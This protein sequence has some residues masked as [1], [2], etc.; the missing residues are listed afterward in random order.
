MKPAHRQAI[1]HLVE[2]LVLDVHRILVE[3][4][5]FVN[6]HILRCLELNL[7]LPPTISDTFLY[8]AH[9]AVT[10]GIDVNNDFWHVEAHLV[11]SLAAYH[12]W[13]PP[14]PVCPVVDRR[15]WIRPVRLFP[16][17]SPGPDSCSHAGG[18]PRAAPTRGGA[19]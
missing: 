13:R 15:A 5:L 14:A 6:F 4:H 17:G 8:R 2:E 1:N 16:R 3:T 10:N 18:R 19:Q 9:A 12:T 11:D 7:P